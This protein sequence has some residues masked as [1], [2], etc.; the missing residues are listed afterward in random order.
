MAPNQRSVLLYENDDLERVPSYE[1]KGE[2]LRRTF[3]RDCP[4]YAVMR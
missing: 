3:C 1:K 2:H 4:S